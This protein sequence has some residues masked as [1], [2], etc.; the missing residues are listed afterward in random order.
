MK[1]NNCISSIFWSTTKIDKYNFLKIEKKVFLSPQYNNTEP[2]LAV[3][4]PYRDRS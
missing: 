1:F 2:N 3:L 4:N